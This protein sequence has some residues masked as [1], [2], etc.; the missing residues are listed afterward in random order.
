MADHYID[1][2]NE[3]DEIIGKELKSK[4]PELGFISRV[5]AVMLRDSNDK[6]IV[7][8]RGSHKILDA[9]KYDLA[10]FG[11]VDSGENYGQAAKRELKEEL[12]LHC[13][14]TML[15][16]FYQEIEHK[17]N[18][19]RIFCGVFLGETDKEPELNHEL[20]SFKRMTFKE[21]ETEMKSNPE[22]F[23]PGFVNDFNQ[24]K[25]KLRIKN[26]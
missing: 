17:G 2:V 6:F 7:C 18:K 21:I 3:K 23:C 13:K 19:L 20:V 5:V 14:L 8:K 22:R 12:N 11:N 1:I 4:K 26:L 24:V 25:E 10:A 16:K 9:E 15:D